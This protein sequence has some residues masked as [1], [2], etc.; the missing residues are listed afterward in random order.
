LALAKK[1][2]EIWLKPC[3]VGILL[4][5]NSS[6]NLIPACG[7]QVLSSTLVEKNAHHP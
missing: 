6:L 1:I 2:A 3:D 5:G 4:S 7:R